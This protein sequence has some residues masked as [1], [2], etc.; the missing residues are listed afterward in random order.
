MAKTGTGWSG[1]RP[2]GETSQG[3]SAFGKL[4][5]QILIA[6]AVGILLGHFYPNAGVEMKPIGDAFISRD[7]VFG[8]GIAGG[9]R[10]SAGAKRF[11][12]AYYPPSTT[13]QYSL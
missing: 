5:I 13:G 12:A 3:G 1:M 8:C 10:R 11:G 4:Y 2:R 9:R 7:F 6:I